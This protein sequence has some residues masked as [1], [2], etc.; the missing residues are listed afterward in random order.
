MS[1]IFINIVT[2]KFVKMQML[3]NINT[4]TLEELKNADHLFVIVG[5]GRSNPDGYLNLALNPHLKN[6]N[7]LFVD[8][9]P[10]YMPDIVALIQDV[11]FDAFEIANSNKIF[12]IFCFD[13][14]SFFCTAIYSLPSIAKR[15]NSP[16]VVF[17]PLGDGENKI[18]SEITHALHEPMFTTKIMHGKYPLFDWEVSNAHENNV[19]TY[20]NKDVY[21]GIF[22]T[23]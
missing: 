6:I 9:N 13:Y 2:Q 14:S 23:P 5:R 15:I 8:P 7:T 19:A 12:K 18:P 10:N 20:V 1:I 11:N 16:F 17:V 3:N 21:I 4:F 22:V